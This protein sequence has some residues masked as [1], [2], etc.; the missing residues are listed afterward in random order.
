LYENTARIPVDSGDNY[1]L[2]A[3]IH[4]LLT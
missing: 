3:K 1:L 4:N 2:L